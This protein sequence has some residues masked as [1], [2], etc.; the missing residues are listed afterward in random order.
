MLFAFGLRSLDLAGARYRKRTPAGAPLASSAAAGGVVALATVLDGIPE[1]LIIGLNF[2]E[3]KALGFATVIAVLLSNFPEGVAST[4]RMRA[5]GRSFPYVHRPV[6]VG[7]AH[8]G[9][10]RLGRLPLPG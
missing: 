1:S 5:E 2:S 9:R 8:L 4:A 7:R 3:G 6:G 10:L